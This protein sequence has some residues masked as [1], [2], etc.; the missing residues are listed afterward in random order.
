MKKVKLID[1]DEWFDLDRCTD[2]FSFTE[3]TRTDGKTQR[4]IL[5]TRNGTLVT[6]TLKNGTFQCRRCNEDEIIRY[7]NRYK[8]PESEEI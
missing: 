1:T 2:S 5:K 6:R 4:S 8:Y 7:E 3:E